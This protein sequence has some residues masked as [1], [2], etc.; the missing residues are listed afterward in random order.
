MSH[1]GDAADAALLAHEEHARLLA[2]Y[3]P[4]ILGRCIARLYGHADAEDVAQD[5]KLRLW[6]ELQAGK[7]PDLREYLARAGDGQEELA[8]LVDRF[9]QW[10]EPG[11]P[12]EDAVGVAQAWIEGEAPLV[13]LRARRGM[14]REWVVDALMER[15]GLAAG[16]REKVGRRYH[17]LETG[18]L[19]L[20]QVDQAL[21]DELAVLFKA[22]IGDLL[23][24][25]PRPVT[26]QAVYYRANPPIASERAADAIAVGTAAE[27]L[28]LLGDPNQLPQVSQGSH[29]PGA[30]A[31]VL[32]HLLGDDETVRPD[33]GLF[34]EHTWRMRAEVCEFIST[35]FYEGR[36]ESG[37]LCAERSV[38][39]GNGVRYLQ[40]EHS[41]HRQ[42]SPEEAAVVAAE[43]DRLLGTPFRDEHGS[44][45]LGP[46]DFVVVAPYNAHVRRLREQILDPRIRI[47]TVDKFQGQQAPVVFYSMASSSGEDVPRGLDFLL[48]RNRLNVAISRAQCLAYLVCSPRLLEVNCR[49]IEQ[50]RLANA[51]CRFVEL[52]EET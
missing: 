10:A 18:Q 29:P 44:R 2:K 7:R 35:S 45:S 12:D 28:V 25:Q 1:D 46:D 24:W 23:A 49:T 36:L 13:A 31:S 41:G 19:E 52:A 6:R 33:M 43:I 51:L 4:V 34:L 26:A 48:S 14:K 50:M 38:E 11:E 17:E 39:L 20:R 5:A 37:D 30:E 3:E 9:L 40:V 42:A 21:L 27:N 8:R 22:R 32:A 16:L 47:G 15:F